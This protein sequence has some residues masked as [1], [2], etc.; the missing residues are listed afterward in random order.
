VGVEEKRTAGR[1]APAVSFLM[2]S[3][4]NQDEWDSAPAAA[5]RESFPEKI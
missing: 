2:N 1:K 3:N 4:W 5:G